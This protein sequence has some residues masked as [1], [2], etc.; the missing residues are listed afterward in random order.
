MRVQKTY[1]MSQSLR[2]SMQPLSRNSKKSKKKKLRPLKPA[3]EPP[4]D[5]KSDV[6]TTQTFDVNSALNSGSFGTPFGMLIDVVE[7]YL[8]IEFEMWLLCGVWRNDDGYVVCV[9]S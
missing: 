3:A 1:K 8:D 7:G 9:E 5:P 4:P 6:S 2:K